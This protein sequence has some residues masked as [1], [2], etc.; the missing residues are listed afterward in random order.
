MALLS[1]FFGLL[2]VFCLL[3]FIAPNNPSGERQKN[4][5]DNNKD[6]GESGAVCPPAGRC[7]QSDIELLTK[8][9]GSRMTSGNA[10]PA[11]DPLDVLLCR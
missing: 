8:G 11:V 2:F 5:N 9:L 6:N 1:V 4:H 3:S 7:V 10:S